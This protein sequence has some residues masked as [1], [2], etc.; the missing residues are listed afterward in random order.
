MEHEQV[1]RREVACEGLGHL[2]FFFPPAH[3]L[4]CLSGPPSPFLPQ[5][6]PPSS[7]GGARCL[8]GLSMARTLLHSTLRWLYI[9]YMFF[10]QGGKALHP[11]QVAEGPDTQAP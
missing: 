6:L 11:V 10:H 9:S 7:C 5:T 3:T 8:P 1:G 4:P 2:C